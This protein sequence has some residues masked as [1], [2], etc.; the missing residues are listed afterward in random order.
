[1]GSTQRVDRSLRGSVRSSK[2]L[3][4]CLAG[5]VAVLAPL[6]GKA[7]APRR[8]VSL[9]VC[10]DQLAMMI[11]DDQ[12]L[13]S[14]SHL[15]SDPRVS[16]MAD[17]AAAYTTNF[18]RAEEVFLMKPDLVI[19][20]AYTAKATVA[21][22]RQFGIPVE[23]FTPASG[24][25]DVP[26]K[27]VQMGEALGREPEAAALVDEFMTRLDTLRR[28]VEHRPRAAMYYAN[29][30]TTGDQSLAGQILVAAGFSNIAVEAGVS[31]GGRLPL[32]VLAMSDPDMVVTGEK[33]LG[34]SRSEAIFDHPVVQDI[35]QSGSVG[36][37]TDRD[38]ICGTPFVLRAIEG[39]ADARTKL[40][41]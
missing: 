3:A 35:A 22:L 40:D 6:P 30:Y 15:A 41:N 16:A 11:A 39:L 34:A 8:V 19:A 28:Q 2:A 31:G 5:V 27:L 37:V 9:N 17:A 33:Y 21:M 18:A 13:I 36:T 24:I 1:M 10:T 7:D 26:D 23:V 38:W 25:D 29:G 4:I 14:V 12:Q 32:E 20:G